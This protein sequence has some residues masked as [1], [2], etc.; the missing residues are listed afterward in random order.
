MRVKP[1]M[2]MGMP[3]RCKEL[4]KYGRH[5]SWILAH[6][7][8]CNKSQKGALQHLDQ[9]WDNSSNSFCFILIPV[10]HHLMG[11]K[12]PG[13]TCC[14]DGFMFTCK[15]N[16][17]H[18]TVHNFMFYGWQFP[19]HFLFSTS[20]PN[21]PPA[22]APPSRLLDPEMAASLG[23]HS[24]EQSWNMQLVMCCASLSISKTR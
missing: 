9:Q 7:K 24:N 23:I 5:N 8:S 6:A 17:K 1:P 15:K 11:S 13:K 10:Q 16:V 18:G 20:R 4:E 3:N 14:G 21:H 22:D 2:Y 12:K 19:F